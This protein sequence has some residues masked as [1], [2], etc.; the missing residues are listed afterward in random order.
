MTD[1]PHLIPPLWPSL[2]SQEDETS[3]PAL[4]SLLARAHC[5]FGFASAPKDDGIARLGRWLENSR[6]RVRLI[7]TVYPTCGTTAV[8]LRALS[9]LA[10][11]FGSELE[12]RI[13][14]LGEVHERMS[15]ALCVSE[16]AEGPH[17]LLTGP[18][19]DLGLHCLSAQA[20]NL[21]VKMPPDVLAA[22][23]E[24]FDRH[25]AASRDLHSPGALDIPALVL[26]VGSLEAAEHWHEY[27]NGLGSAAPFMAEGGSVEK[28]AQTCL[29]PDSELPETI[30]S[31]S[32]AAPESIA[33]SLGL[34]KVDKLDRRMAQIYEQ[35]YLVTI[36]ELSRLKPFD[37]PIDPHYFG[38]EADIKKGSVSR[39]ISFKIS[40]FSKEDLKR[41]QQHREGM[42]T[43]LSRFSFGLGKGIKWI[44]KKAVEHFDRERNRLNSAAQEAVRDLIKEDVRELL[45][46]RSDMIRHDLEEIS[47]ELGGHGRATSAVVGKVMEALS[48]RLEMAKT[49][50]FMPQLSLT[51]IAFNST[52]SEGA[53]PWGQAFTLLKNV[54]E[55]PRKAEVQANFFGEL[56]VDEDDLIAAMNVAGDSMI[57]RTRDRKTAP[58]CRQELD[59]LTQIEKANIPPRQRC[60][61]VFMILDGTPPDEIFAKLTQFESEGAE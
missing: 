31:D 41:L 40:P 14:A 22:F 57:G 45:D 24:N 2:A 39:R 59:L 34:R 1:N 43:L 52:E 27:Q 55:Y 9:E 19:E 7:V 6:L 21:A 44:P 10:E 8:Q 58:R 53:S 30:V 48:K 15:N 47:R 36:D 29:I 60:E 16:A 4:D 18:G 54:A 12:V 56:E 50:N 38:E 46:S 49:Q 35:G 33:D 17:Y 37:V 11:R 32:P 25:W 5:I 26:P 28:S 13:R 3:T 20:F 42:R 23:L 61:L 51:D